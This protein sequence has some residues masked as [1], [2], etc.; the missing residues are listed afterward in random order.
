MTLSVFYKKYDS[1]INKAVSDALRED[2]TRNDITTDLLLNVKGTTGGKKI[3]A[4]LL[5]KEDCILAGIEIFK[6]VY[7]QLD[8]NVSFRT[9]YK[10]GAVLKSRTKV[11]KSINSQKSSDG[12]GRLNFLQ[13]MTGIATLTNRFRKN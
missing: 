8:K 10:D 12:K 7:R 4:V 6:K 5:C 13:R 1:S 3:S 2:R 11:L 9:Y